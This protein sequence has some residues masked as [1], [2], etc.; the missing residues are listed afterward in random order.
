VTFCLQD[1]TPQCCIRRRLIPT[2]RG[3]L[4]CESWMLVEAL[5]L[6]SSWMRRTL[7]MVD[8][9]WRGVDC[10]LSVTLGSAPFS[11]SSRAIC[12]QGEAMLRTCHWKLIYF[13][14]FFKSVTSH[15]QILFCFGFG[16]RVKV[17]SSD[18]YN[19]MTSVDLSS[20]EGCKVHFCFPIPY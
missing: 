18:Q 2:Y 16:T 12:N 4:P 3:V 20:D 8:T 19:E 17:T 15:F 7:P 11:N 1:H 6:R 14:Y 10:N 5:C 9:L 13:I